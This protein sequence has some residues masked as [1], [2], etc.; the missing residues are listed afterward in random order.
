[1]LGKQQVCFN[2]E[3]LTVSCVLGVAFVKSYQHLPT[4]LW[5]Y[6]HSLQNYSKYESKLTAE[7]VFNKINRIV[8]EFLPNLQC[9]RSETKYIPQTQKHTHTL[10]P[11][12]CTQKHMRITVTV[13]K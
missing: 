13:Q 5:S 2:S 3:T 11:S 12:V 8:L 4:Y 6:V 9:R 1:M 10:P 7:N